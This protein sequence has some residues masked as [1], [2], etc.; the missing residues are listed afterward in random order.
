[1]ESHLS[2][3]EKRNSHKKHTRK[4]LNGKSHQQRQNCPAQI[5]KKNFSG[6][7]T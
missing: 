7:V 6:E 5:K 4:P 2:R 3:K 1:M